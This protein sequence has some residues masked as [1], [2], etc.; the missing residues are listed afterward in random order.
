MRANVAALRARLRPG[1]GL[2]A[3][4]KADGYGHGAHEVGRAATEAGATGLAVA[5]AGEAVSLRDGGY[6]GPLLVMGPLYD[7]SEPAALAGL[8]VDVTV[9]ADDLLDLLHGLPVGGPP[10]RLHV[11]VDTG[12]NRQGLRPPEL[13][14]FLDVA[15]ALPQVEITGVMTHFAC[16][17]S[18]PECVADQLREFIPCVEQIKAGWPHAVVHA[19]NSA[20]AL[21]HPETHFDLARCGIAVFGLSPYQDDP[22]EYGLRPALTWSSVLVS[23]KD[24]APGDAVGYGHT[25]TS[26]RHTRVGLVPVGYADGMRRLLGNR[27]TVLVGGRRCAI[28]GR[29]SMDSFTIDMGP[30]SPAKTGDRVTMIGEEGGERITAEEMAE[31]I[32]TINYEITCGLQL[33]R[34]RRVYVDSE[35]V[36]RPHH[37]TP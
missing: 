12:M 30:D 34:A 10:L 20:A 31:L 29:V 13:E 26:D 7:L 25:F 15:G 5:T 2:L 27:G 1:S 33:E 21:G 11:K 35:E 19:A 9:V 6:A 32:G 17:D 23:V 36:P 28:I 14:R 3:V 16:A 24:L 22:A 37:W 4:V 18:D 8:D